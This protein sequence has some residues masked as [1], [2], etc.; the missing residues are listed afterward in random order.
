MTPAPRRWIGPLA[1]AIAGLAMLAW[2]WRRWPDVLVDFGG[3]LYV[4]WR[5]S[6]GDVLYRDV[7]Y[8]TGPLSPYLNA[9]VFK[10]FGTSFMTLVC[11]N[12]AV[13]ALIAAAVHRLLGLV[14][15][16]VGAATGTLAFLTLFAFAQLEIYGNSNYVT[17]YAHETTHGT[18]I[19]LAALLALARWMRTRRLGWIAAAM[20]AT[21]A[22]FAHT[23]V[24]KLA[25]NTLNT[26]AFRYGDSGP[27]K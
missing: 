1:C 4:P 3:E 16:R 7:A 13:L 15:D 8:F 18:L 27:V 6:Q 10:V 21:T 14:S 20:S 9:L 19:A 25:P 17:P 26:S 5:L 12:L 24:M 23:S 2:T 11:A 22:R